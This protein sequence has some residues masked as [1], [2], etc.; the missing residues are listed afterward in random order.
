LQNLSGDPS[1]D[2]FADGM[3]EELIT[4]LSHIAALRVISRTSVMLYKKSNRPLPPIARELNV[5]AI[6]EGSVLR[7][8][9]RVRIAA[10][11]IRAA[12]DTN[13]WAETY[14]RDLRDVL[15]LQSVV[16]RTLADQVRAEMTPSERKRIQAPW[17]VNLAALEAYLQGQYYE[18]NI[19]SGSSLE[20]RTGNPIFC[21]KHTTV[22][23]D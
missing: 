14:A 15:T 21:A 7:S 20:G 11:L 5:E 12:N 9:H 18:N 2:Y 16:A 17:P 1:Q 23:E 3:T 22:S 10:Q 6:V 8:G 4:E 19:G 13:L